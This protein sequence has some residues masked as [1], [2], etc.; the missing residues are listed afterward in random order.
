M[1][2]PVQ[3]EPPA[4]CSVVPVETAQQ[5][6]AACEQALPVDVAI[7]A[8]AVGDWRVETEAVHKIKKGD[9]ANGDGT[10]GP[11]NLSLTENTDI[12]QT[13][14]M[15]GDR[16]PKLVIGFAAETTALIENA[17]KKLAAKGCDW[18]V[19]NDV[20]PGRDVF[21]GSEN[22]VHLISAD[23]VEDWPRMSKIDLARRL[24]DRIA[25]AIG[26]GGTIARLDV[27]SEPRANALDKSKSV[28]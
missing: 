28:S 12:L 5:M 14:S 16:R 27:A 11:P 4:G 2:G 1:T 6:L 20:S 9:P 19:A 18:I 26:G 3:I 25:A 17:T 22:T 23:G 21:G 10:A 24:A 13:I 8:A 7:F 15:V